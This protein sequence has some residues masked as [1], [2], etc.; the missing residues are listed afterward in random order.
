MAKS[1][2]SVRRLQAGFVSRPINAERFDEAPAALCNEN[3]LSWRTILINETR[4]G[5]DE[6]LC[7]RCCRDPK[8]VYHGL[9]RL[10]A[11]HRATRDNLAQKFEAL[12]SQIGVGSRAASAKVLMRSRLVTKTG[13][14]QI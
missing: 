6:I 3:G 14:K 5:T 4:Y 12:A 8:R 10:P 13:S 2:A 11:H 9:P 1:L 7:S